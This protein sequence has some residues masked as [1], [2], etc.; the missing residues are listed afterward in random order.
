[1]PIYFRH[2]LGTSGFYWVHIDT[3]Q[4]ISFPDKA[5]NPPLFFLPDQHL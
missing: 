4:F 3:E 5:A 1:M 2:F